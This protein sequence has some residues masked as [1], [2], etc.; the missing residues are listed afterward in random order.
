MIRFACRLDRPSFSFEVAFEAGSGVTALFGPSGCG[1]STAIRLLAGLERPA[2][3][4]IAIGPQVLVDTAARIWRAPHRRRMGLVFQDAHLFPHLSVRR[5]LLYGRWF[6][7]TAERPIGFDSVVEVLGIGHLLARAPAKLS[8]GERQRVAIGRALLSSP[9]VL[10]MDEPLASLDAARKQEIL[11]FIERLRDEFAIPIIYV[12]HALD[13]VSR[14]ADKVV[15][16]REGR[17][18]AEGGPEAVEIISILTTEPWDGTSSHGLA[19][20]AHPAGALFLH[21]AALPR[22]RPLRVAVK[23]SD[24]IVALGTPEA[25]SIVSTLMGRVSAIEP[26]D[27]AFARVD[28]AL[29]SGETLRA[30]ITRLSI[31]ELQLTEGTEVFALVKAAA[32]ADRRT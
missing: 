20:L 11:P 3:G 31:E 16:L 8:G 19:R 28:I 6:A 9:R 17:V 10:L 32:L 1:K 22:D 21:D 18:A 23:A 4:R 25:S 24:V 14:L 27:E 13:E 7:P 12:S 30:M 2:E 5:N 26:L 15:H 29:S